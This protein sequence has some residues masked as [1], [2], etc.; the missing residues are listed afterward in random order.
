MSG[1]KNKSRP[2]EAAERRTR[3]S[4]TKGPEKF[5]ERNAESLPIKR[6]AGF[7]HMDGSGTLHIIFLLNFFLRFSMAA[8]V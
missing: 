4:L 8:F 3:R 7:L 1:G 6:S 2:E 5:H